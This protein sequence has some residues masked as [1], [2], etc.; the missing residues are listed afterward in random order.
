[1]WGIR[2]IRVGLLLCGCLATIAGSG[3]RSDCQSLWDLGKSLKEKK[4]EKKEPDTLPKW[5][6]E[7]SHLTPEKIHG[8]IY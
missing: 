4:D 1:M 8:G 3:C 7:P 5:N 6:A 2:A